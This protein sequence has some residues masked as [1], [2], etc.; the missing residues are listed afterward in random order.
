ML[1]SGHH[2]SLFEEVLWKVLKQFHFCRINR[3]LGDT[4]KSTVKG[5]LVCCALAVSKFGDTLGTFIAFM[6]E[7]LA[8]IARP[9]IH[10]EQ[11]VVYNR[12]KNKTSLEIPGFY[13]ARRV[14]FPVYW[15]M[16][17]RWHGWTMRVK[18]GFEYRLSKVLQ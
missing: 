11:N 14:E 16:E 2:E 10:E 7:I 3:L 18:S 1:L 17:E 13:D 4:L 6:D 9:K 5:N 15:L 8:E 12:R